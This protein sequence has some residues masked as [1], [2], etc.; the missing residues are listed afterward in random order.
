LFERPKVSIAGRASV[1]TLVVLLGALA[2]GAT[3]DDDEGRKAWRD[4]PARYLLTD[5]EYR[6]Y[7]ELDADEDRRAFVRDFW[8]RLDPDPSTPRNAFREQYDEL[9][10]MANR[11]FDGPAGPGWRTDRG[12]ILILLG[13]PGSVARDAGGRYASDREVWTYDRASGPSEVVFY[14]ADDGTFRLNIGEERPEAPDALALHSLQ[15]ARQEL[16]RELQYDYGFLSQTQ[17]DFLLQS[18]LPDPTAGEVGAPQWDAPEPRTT[19]KRGNASIAGDDDVIR[20][21][22][23]A[24]YFLA[25]DG[26]VMT[27]FAVEVD[28]VEIE[29]A[30]GDGPYS[31]IAWVMDATAR[32]RPRSSATVSLLALEPDTS[33]SRPGRLLL[34]GRLYLPAGEYE[35]AYAVR[36]ADAETLQVRFLPMVVPRLETTRV[37]TSS[38]VPAESFGAAPEASGSP[39]A[40]GSDRVVPR[41]GGVFHRGE[42]LRIYLQVYGAGTAAEGESGVDIRLRFARA[43]GRR[44]KRHGKPLSLEGARGASVGLALPI[45]DWPPGDYR[46][47]VEI[48][49]RAAGKKTSTQGFFTIA[50]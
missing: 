44:Y 32:D 18:L 21:D 6:L 28:G 26:S 25:A 10:R 45:G 13:V 8:K 15:I 5:D 35:V 50:E 3:S 2:S 12:R 33:G 38:V 20:F 37:S 47:E 23:D 1:V 11:L 30:T 43:T 27:L 42:P 49:D 7:G 16:A 48:R 46:V 17:R 36:N 4:G 39:F 29:A 14:R 24:Y 40:V 34:G 9:T 41:P 31:A 22:Q 19:R